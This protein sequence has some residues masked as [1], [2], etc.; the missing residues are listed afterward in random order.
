MMQTKLIAALAAVLLL[1]ATYF[2]G[3][4]NGKALCT[5][6][7]LVEYQ[8]GVRQNE[9]TEKNIKQLDVHG[10]DRVLSNWVQPDDT[11]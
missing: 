2:Y 1:V 6:E 3:Q 7:T 4:S 10:L 9:V 11:Q 5:G 8:K